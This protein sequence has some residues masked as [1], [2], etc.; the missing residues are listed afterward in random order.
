M[1]GYQSLWHG[2]PKQCKLEEIVQH[3]FSDDDKLPDES[4]LSTDDVEEE[5]S[6]T[7]ETSS[8][9]ETSAPA[10]TVTGTSSL[11]IYTYKSNLEWSSEPTP[12]AKRMCDSIESSFL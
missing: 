1:K 11:R 3:V 10:V 9:N 8:G 5:M 6:E 2:D 7:L 12:F 4:T